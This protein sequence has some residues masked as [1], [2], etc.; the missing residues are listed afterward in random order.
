[1][2]EFFIEQFQNLSE[3]MKYIMTFLISMIPIVELR[4]AIPVGT[5]LGLD[6]LWILVISIIGNLIP[7]PFIILFARPIIRWLK[8]TK[9]FAPLANWLEASANVGYVEAFFIDDPTL[10]LVNIE[11]APCNGG[12]LRE[13]AISGVTEPV[14]GE[15]PDYDFIYSQGFNRGAAD[16]CVIWYDLTAGKALT[17]DD[18]FVYGHTYELLLVLCSDKEING[19]EGKFEFAPYRV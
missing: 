13:I 3:G 6:T 4:G 17:E 11:F 7:V 10:A 18:V 8:K 5:A 14:A 16:E 15:H 9:M 1:M 2:T 19:P 12:V